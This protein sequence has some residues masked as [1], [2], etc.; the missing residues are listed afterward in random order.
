M[1]SSF[2]SERAC[3]DTEPVSYI[4]VLQTKH[5]NKSFKVT[6]NITRILIDNMQSG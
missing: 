5:D 4:T 1:C 3:E 6:L 2:Q